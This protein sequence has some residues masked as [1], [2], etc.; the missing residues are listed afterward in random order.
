MGKQKKPIFFKVTEPSSVPYRAPP[1]CAAANLKIMMA[2]YP[3]SST[4]SGVSGFVPC[5]YYV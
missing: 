5:G 1:A 3:E 2:A 4:R